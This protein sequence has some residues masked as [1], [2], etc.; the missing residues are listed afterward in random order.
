MEAHGRVTGRLLCKV[1]GFTYMVVVMVV[2]S[3]GG[4][5]KVYCWRYNTSSPYTTTATQ[6]FMKWCVVH[7]VD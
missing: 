7:L 6:L 3:G 1:V 4:K 5:I 2:V